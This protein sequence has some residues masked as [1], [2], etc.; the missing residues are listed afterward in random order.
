MFIMMVMACGM[1]T[2]D[3]C[4]LNPSTHG[5]AGGKMCCCSRVRVRPQRR[6]PQLR[7]RGAVGV[8]PAMLA[9]AAREASRRA[10]A[11]LRRYAAAPALV[12]DVT[13]PFTVVDYDGVRHKCVGRVGH[14]LVKSMQ[15]QGLPMVLMGVQGY[16]AAVRVSREFQGKVPEMDL[17]HVRAHA[18]RAEHACA[19]TRDWA[20]GRLGDWA[21]PTLKHAR[22]LRAACTRHRLAARCHRPCG[23]V[24][25]RILA[26]A[27]HSSTLPTSPAPS[28][29]PTHAHATLFS[30]VPPRAGRAGRADTARP[31]SRPCRATAGCPRA[32]ARAARHLSA[33]EQD[34]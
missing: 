5:R 19:R 1:R 2:R 30:N 9:R 16:D 20:I 7:G 24:P 23:C 13:V 11:P 31:P 12:S 27:C 17:A 8:P 21:C 15:Q 14:N 3:R 25:A 18:A 33:E 29:P 6:A 10:A 22:A 4:N 28:L 26:G 32:R 34:A